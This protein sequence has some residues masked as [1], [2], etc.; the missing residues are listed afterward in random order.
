[1]I[2]AR[3]LLSVRSNSPD[4]MSTI[5]PKKRVLVVDDEIGFTRLLK[6]TLEKAGKYEI[7]I[8]NDGM[9][10]CA[11]AREFLPDIVFL[12]IVMPEIDGGDVAQQ[13]RADAK[14]AKVPVV[15]LTAL[16]AQRETQKDIGGFP[17]LAKPVSTAALIACIEEKTKG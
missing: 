3:I 12:D 17:F 2:T 1:M 5:S 6:L 9:K 8:E 16:V 7:R 13:I 10:A 4:S 15:F 11:V 14:L